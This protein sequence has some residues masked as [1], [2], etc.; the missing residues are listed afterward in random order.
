MYK[1]RTRAYYIEYNIILIKDPF[2]SVVNVN[3]SVSSG[4]RVGR[5]ELYVMKE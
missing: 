5:G 3:T 1:A 2:H 4:G